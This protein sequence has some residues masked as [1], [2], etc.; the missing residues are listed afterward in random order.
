MVLD[1]IMRF[2]TADTGMSSPKTITLPSLDSS[3]HPAR[4]AKKHAQVY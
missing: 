2:S 1:L 3:A 4:S